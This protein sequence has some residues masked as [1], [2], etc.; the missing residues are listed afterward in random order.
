MKKNIIG[1]VISAAVFGVLVWGASL[2]FSFSFLDW[3]F[4]IGLAIS[5]V[6]F[7][8][9]SSGGMLSKNATLDASTA[10]WKIQQDN[11]LKANVGF[12]FYGAVLFTVISFIMMIVTYY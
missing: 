11:E 9:N 1:T 3:G 8:F 7:F 10:G 2:I 5:V 12:V 4:F 6:L